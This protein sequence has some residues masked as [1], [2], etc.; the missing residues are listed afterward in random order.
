MPRT[1]RA[2]A[3]FVFVSLL[4]LAVGALGLGLSYTTAR[5]VRQWSEPS[6]EVGQEPDTPADQSSAPPTEQTPP[7]S[8][9][10][11]TE[12]Q[13][14]DTEPV[15]AKPALPPS[16]AYTVRPVEREEGQGGDL[17]GIFDSLDALVESRPVALHSL[18]P[19]DRQALL[20]GIATDTLDAARA[21][22]SD[23]CE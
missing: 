12:P 23:F 9:E 4:S 5:A 15:D 8:T 2:S 7:P 10:A 1:H 17:L 18:Y 11:P 16:T 20:E 14:E 19:D 22:L 21:L 3:F 6:A 13:E